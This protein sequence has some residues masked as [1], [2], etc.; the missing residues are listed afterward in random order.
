[1]SRLVD[2]F[3]RTGFA[4]LSSLI[5]AL[6]MAAWA[7]SAD[8]SPIDKTA[9]PWV[10]LAIGLVMLVVWF[11]LLSRL[12]KISVT[13]R[14]RRFDMAQMSRSEKVWIL[15]AVAFAA[16]LIAWLNAAATVDWGPLGSAIGSGKAG[17]I[18]FAAGLAV[19]VV[20]MVAGIWISVAKARLAFRRRVAGTNA[21]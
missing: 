13:P 14:E 18:A 1:M 4:A 11:V 2:R 21:A 7:G 12:A 8:L 6:P 15:A 19:Y 3:G 17:P 10:A 16:G 9:Y 20:V 5:W